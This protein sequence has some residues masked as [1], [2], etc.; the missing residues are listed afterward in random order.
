MILFEVNSESLGVP[1]VQ[2]SVS[3]LPVVKKSD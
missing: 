1:L 2:V 3:Q